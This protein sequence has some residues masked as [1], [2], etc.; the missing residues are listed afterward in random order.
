MNP[1]P[2]S[3]LS[4]RRRMAVGVW[5]LLIASMAL[6]TS[7]L[8]TATSLGIMLSISILSLLTRIV[9]EHERPVHQLDSTWSR[10]VPLVISLL[11]PLVWSAILSR[12]VSSEIQPLLVLIAC[13]PV[14][15]SLLLIPWRTSNPSQ[16]RE[17]SRTSVNEIHRSGHA[18]AA[19]FSEAIT[20]ETPVE[21]ESVSTVRFFESHSAEDESPVTAEELP[22]DVTQW[23]TRSQTDDGEVIK[24]GF[25][26]DFADGQRDAT[27]HLSFCPP[28]AKVPQIL[29]EDLDGQNLEVTIA[30]SFPFGAR[31]SVRRSLPSKSGSTTNSSTGSCRIGFVA[32]AS[33]LRR[34]A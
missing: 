25:R 9:I 33:S 20:E 17:E 1:V 16:T 7:R 10:L 24:G 34:T 12:T 29:A 27:I 14:C 11:I 6:D 22:P 21:E 4:S 31:I 2:S 28:F 13:G 19:T 15:I 5:S 32:S 23:L 26:V 3:N 30:A 8:S 18:L